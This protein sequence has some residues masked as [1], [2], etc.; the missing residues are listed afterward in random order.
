MS[1]LLIGID[2]GGTNIK[3]G[4]FDAELNLI[5]KGSVETQADMGA[6]AV[7]ERMA[8][9]AEKITADAGCDFVDVS[10][11][12]IGTPGPAD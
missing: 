10:A 5:G 12:G 3:V 4:C 11:I 6:A 1:E 9:A 7:V 8:G 2:L